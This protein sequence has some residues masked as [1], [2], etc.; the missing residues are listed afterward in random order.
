MINIVLG[1][2]VRIPVPTARRHLADDRHAAAIPA[3]Y[4]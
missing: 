1:R 4:R 3:R 2:V